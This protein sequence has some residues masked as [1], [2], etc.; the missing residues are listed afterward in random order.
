MYVLFTGNDLLTVGVGLLV[1][2]VV[3]VLTHITFLSFTQPLKV[4]FLR[5]RV[6]VGAVPIPH[7]SRAY[8]SMVREEDRLLGLLREIYFIHMLYIS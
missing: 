7:L 3:I 2:P 1:S 4:L 8:D 5:V 6:A